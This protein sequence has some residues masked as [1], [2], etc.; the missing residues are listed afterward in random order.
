MLLIQNHQTQLVI[1]L[2]CFAAG[3]GLYGLSFR[4]RLD[5]DPPLISATLKAFLGLLLLLL[6]LTALASIFSG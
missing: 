5:F 1:A 2:S 4:K 3:G 6:G